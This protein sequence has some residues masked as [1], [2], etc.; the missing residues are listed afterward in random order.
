MIE[1]ALPDLL[2]IASA[3]PASHGFLDPVPAIPY[4]RSMTTVTGRLLT[5]RLSRP[6]S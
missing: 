2:S 1:A 6:A 5:L 3:P 4:L